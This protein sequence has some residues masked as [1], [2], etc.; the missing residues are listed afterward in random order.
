VPERLVLDREQD[1]GQA[2]AEVMDEPQ[3]DLGLQRLDPPYAPRPELE[4]RCSVAA[5]RGAAKAGIDGELGDSPRASGGR[6]DERDPA[7]VQ[8]ANRGERSLR[9]R[10]VRADQRSVEVGGDEPDQ[11]TRT[12][13][14][15]IVRSPE[16]STR[17][18][19]P[20]AQNSM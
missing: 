19:S 13:T 14:D 10:P 4:D 5:D 1:P 20:S 18:Q 15:P 11:K 7:L 9:D 12:T 16:R 2:G 6:D 3:R 8:P 17:R